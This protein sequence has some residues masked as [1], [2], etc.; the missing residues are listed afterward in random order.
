MQR[1]SP[2]P[3]THTALQELFGVSADNIRL[4]STHDGSGV[5]A[6]LLALIAR[7]TE[8]AGHDA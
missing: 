5:G 1:P 6:G 7:E 2:Y 8:K 3:H 4:T